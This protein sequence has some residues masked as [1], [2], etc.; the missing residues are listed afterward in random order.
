MNTSRSSRDSIST[1]EGLHFVSGA[2]K[3]AHLE[4]RR[5]DRIISE[6]GRQKATVGMLG[7]LKAMASPLGGHRQQG[8]PDHGGDP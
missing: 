4:S 3:T 1:C 2:S 8:G 6:N 7:F 5:K